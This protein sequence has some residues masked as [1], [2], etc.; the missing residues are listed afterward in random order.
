MSHVATVKL[1]IRDLEALRAACAATGLELREGQSTYKW[2]G[3]FEP[4]MPRTELD[5]KCDHAIA[6]PP[7]HPRSSVHA[8]E[9]GVARTPSGAFELRFDEDLGDLYS[10]AGARCL[11]LVRAYVGEV[12]R[13][14]LLLQ[15]YV[16]SGRTERADGTVELSFSK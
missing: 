14:T 4:A 16:P 13:K 11:N 2:Y 1:E 3:T 8:Y 7:G 9:I 12:A 15:G 10:L 5:G 6:L